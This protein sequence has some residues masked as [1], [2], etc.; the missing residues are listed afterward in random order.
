MAIQA[1][2]AVAGFN[3]YASVAEADAYHDTV[4]PDLKNLWA[5]AEDKEAA[6]IQA[7]RLLDQAIDWTHGFRTVATQ[8]LCW[9]RKQVNIGGD[10]AEQNGVYLDPEEIPAFLKN[11]T[12]ALARNLS[13]AT[14]P[15]KAL[16]DNFATLNV[17]GISLTPKT[18]T[19][20]PIDAEVLG[21]IS[22]YGRY[23]STGGISIGRIVRGS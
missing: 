22:N 14:N 12:A 19:S 11:A 8:E 9:P 7:S 6:L 21:F 4:H 15:L 13:K 2:P 17:A 3:S 5:D 23:G 20:N 18:D 10:R 1:D 16:S